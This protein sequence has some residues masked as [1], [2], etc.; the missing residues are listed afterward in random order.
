ML[1]RKYVIAAAAAVVLAG[2]GTATALSLPQDDAPAAGTSAAAPNTVD[3]NANTGSGNANTSSGD[4]NSVNGN[5]NKAI[6]AALAAVPGTVTGVDLEDDGHEWD[7]DVYGKDKKW[8]D[9]TVDAA[10]AKVVNQHLDDDNDGRDRNAPQGAPVTVQQAMDAALKAQPGKV[11]EAD[12]E[13][14]RWEIEVAGADGRAHDVNV[15]AKSAKATVVPAQNSD[16]DG[17]GDDD[18]T[19]A[20]SASGAGSDS[21]PDSGSDD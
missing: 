12:L 1:K 11:T 10:G 5:A 18:R 8:H 9:V 6:D 20:G 17:P 2:A 13:N 4:A 21:R 14:G 16:D 7:V 15:D 3:G 19:T